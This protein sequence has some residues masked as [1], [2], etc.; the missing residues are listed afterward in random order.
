MCV[1]GTTQRG[2]VCS[3]EFTLYTPAGLLDFTQRGYVCSG[4]FT[5]YTPAGLLDFTQVS[6]VG[7]TQIQL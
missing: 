2:Y 3:G 7:Y 4:D 5:L 6:M 1:V